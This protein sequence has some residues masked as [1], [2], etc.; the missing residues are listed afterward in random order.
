MFC[1]VKLKPCIASPNQIYGA[2]DDENPRGAMPVFTG[3]YYCPKCDAGNCGVSIPLTEKDVENLARWFEHNPQDL[4]R[5]IPK[6]RKKFA[7]AVKIK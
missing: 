6:I 2:S 5:C 4:K 3:D 1:G 7:G